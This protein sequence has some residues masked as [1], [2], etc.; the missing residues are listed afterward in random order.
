MILIEAI[1]FIEKRLFDDINYDE[2]ARETLTN[3]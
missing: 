2:L 1:N 3:K